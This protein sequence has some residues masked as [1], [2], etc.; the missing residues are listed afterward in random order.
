MNYTRGLRWCA[1]WLVTAC[2]GAPG[3]TDEATAERDASSLA[4]ASAPV[5]AGG[6]A[7]PP[8][9]DEELDRLLDA[10]EQEL[11]SQEPG[12]V[13]PSTGSTRQ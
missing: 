9:S 2:N 6:A 5:N 7:E 13:Q 10:L 4:V 8:L 3:S 12:P 1:L 11:Q